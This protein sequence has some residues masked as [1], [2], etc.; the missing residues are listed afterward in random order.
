M[1]FSF[2]N[3]EQGSKYV[4]KA[5]FFVLQ[6]HARVNPIFESVKQLG[7]IEIIA[8]LLNKDWGFY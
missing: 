7:A 4:A 5:R 3:E 1:P 6:I 8:K 2:S